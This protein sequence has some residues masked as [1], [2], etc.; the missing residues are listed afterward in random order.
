MMKRVSGIMIMHE[1]FQAHLG[2]FDAI[3]NFRKADIEKD[4]QFTSNENMRI[5]CAVIKLIKF[6]LLFLLIFILR[7][8]N[9]SLFLLLNK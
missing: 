9:S 3:C 4:H 6:Q 1:F 8:I 2:Q 5:S 7:N